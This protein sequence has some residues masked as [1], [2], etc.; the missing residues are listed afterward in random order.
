MLRAAIFDIDGTLVDSVDLHALAWHEA[1]KHFG[2]DV[3]VDAA[4]SQIGKG[5]DKLLP[6]FL[7]ED[8]IR[9]HGEALEAWRGKHFKAHY[10][11]LVRPFSAVPALL[12]R[13]SDQGTKLAVGSSAKK[14]ELQVYLDIAGVA[15]RFE[16]TVSSEDVE[17][18]KPDPD[19]FQTALHKLGVQAGEAIAIGDSPYDAQAA[20][21]TGVRTIGV[22]AG[23]F[24]E[25]SLREAGCIDVYTGPAGLLAKFDTSP[26]KAMD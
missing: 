26:L 4:R 8:Q 24:S 15:D 16:V 23:G 25:A 1:F 2:H 18:S 3:S 20:G 12:Q 22:L 21:R 13:L 6:V 9:D 7:S 11:S 10:L 5:G 14:D 17:S 19:V